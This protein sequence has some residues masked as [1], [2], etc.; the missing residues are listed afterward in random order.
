VFMPLIGGAGTPWGAVLGAVIVV[1]LTLDFPAFSESGTLILALGVI[2][3]LLV[4]PRGIIGYVDASRARLLA[5]FEQAGRG[6][7]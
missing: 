2:V 3:I 4:A 6:A 1:E 5:L 7:R